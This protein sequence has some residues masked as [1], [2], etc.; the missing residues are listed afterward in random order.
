MMMSVT[1]T[2][3][4]VSLVQATLPLQG[5]RMPLGLCV[6]IPI[7]NPNPTPA[8]RTVHLS[9]GANDVI[10]DG[11]GKGVPIA[12]FG[13]HMS[14][15]FAR[16]GEWFEI[17]RHSW[18]HSCPLTPS[19]PPT[20]FWNSSSERRRCCRLSPSRS[21]ACSHPPRAAAEPQGGRRRRPARPL[22]DAEPRPSPDAPLPSLPSQPLAV[23][24]AHPPSTARTAQTVRTER[25]ALATR[26]EHGQGTKKRLTCEHSAHA[27]PT[28]TCQTLL[29]AIGF[30]AATFTIH[31]CLPLPRPW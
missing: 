4:A 11:H 6:W 19:C 17:S 29:T 31:H 14:P 21:A 28:K 25:M 12:L 20:E 24:A 27:I 26:L 8:S 15:A 1:S 3:S 16:R 9:N 5:K 7:A 30:R 23:A 2:F 18:H 13:V 22:F 10:R